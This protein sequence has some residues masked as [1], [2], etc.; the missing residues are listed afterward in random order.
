M[1]TVF[2]ARGILMGCIEGTLEMLG[3]SFQFSIFDT[4]LQQIVTT[5]GLDQM[6]HCISRVFTAKSRTNR[7]CVQWNANYLVG[8]NNCT[9]FN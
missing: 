8:C 6:H 3:N 5:K 2:Q 7:C 9:Q 1:M 4:L